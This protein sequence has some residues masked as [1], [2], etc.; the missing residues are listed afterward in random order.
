MP[1]EQGMLLALREGYIGVSGLLLRT[2]AS[3]D[4]SEVDMML[5]IHL[6]YFKE[7]EQ[8]D[9]PTIEQ[10][11]TRLSAAPDVMFQSL[12]KLM[13][14][15]WIAIDE[16][17]DPQTGIH[18]ERYNLSGVYEKLAGA[19]TSLHSS[20]A[21]Q[22]RSDGPLRPLS[23]AAAA[24]QAAA[25]GE[26]QQPDEMAELFSTFER[27]FGRLL[28]PMECETIAGWLDKDRYPVALIYAA[29]KES[30]FAGKVH[31]R[32]IDRI[33]LEWKRHEVRTPEDAKAYAARYR[34]R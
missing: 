29:L 20:G 17:I 19:C 4:L 16:E 30:V 21:L 8:T 6:L 18:Y 26:E 14:E 9:F 32:Y 7:K 13:S 2:Y 3:L 34:G 12:Q 5:I 23:G 27:E 22:V 11:Q 33:L 24:A 28:S 1:F 25:A 10:L 15:G 31:F